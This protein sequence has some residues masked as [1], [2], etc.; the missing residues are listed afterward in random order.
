MQKLIK[1]S[2][3]EI[4]IGRAALRTGAL[5]LVEEMISDVAVSIRDKVDTLLWVVDLKKS[6]YLVECI[7]LV[8]GESISKNKKESLNLSEM[9]KVFVLEQLLGGPKGIIRSKDT[10]ARKIF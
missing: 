2:E 8:T 5:A 6:S 3:S 1:K 4:D 10:I 7:E 9:E